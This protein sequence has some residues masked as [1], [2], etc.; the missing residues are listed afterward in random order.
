MTIPNKIGYDPKQ[1]AYERRI[2]M[3]MNAG[4]TYVPYP[5][6]HMGHP[7]ANPMDPNNTTNNNNGATPTHHG[8]QLTTSP[9]GSVVGTPTFSSPTS[10]NIN[11]Y[12]TMYGTNPTMQTPTSVQ[13]SSSN[14]YNVAP[15]PNNTPNVTP[16]AST[17]N[18]PNSGKKKRKTEGTSKKSTGGGK[19]KNSKTPKAS[20]SSTTNANNNND[21]QALPL[22]SSPTT[23]DMFS[24]NNTTVNGAT[25][26]PSPIATTIMKSSKVVK[27]EITQINEIFDKAFQN[28]TQR[29]QNISLVD[30]NHI[31]TN[32]IQKNVP[33]PDSLTLREEWKNVLQEG[34]SSILPPPADIHLVNSLQSGNN[35]TSTGVDNENSVE[36]T[37]PPMMKPLFNISHIM[38]LLFN[39]PIMEKQEKSL[40]YKENYLDISN[41]ENVNEISNFVT[42]D[43][44][45]VENI[46]ENI[47][48]D[49]E[50][51]FNKQSLQDKES[52]S[53]L[54]MIALLKKKLNEYIEKNREEMEKKLIQMGNTFN[55]YKYIQ[56]H[57]LFEL[58]KNQL[59]KLLDVSNKQ[60]EE[61]I[62]IEF[63]EQQLNMNNDNLSQNANDMDYNL[64]DTED[65]INNNN[66]S[67]DYSKNISLIEMTPKEIVMVFLGKE[68]MTQQQNQEDVNS[69]LERF[70]ELQKQYKI[71]CQY[72]D[73]GLRKWQDNF[74]QLFNEQSQIRIISFEEK[75]R[76]LKSLE[77]RFQY[78]KNLLKEKYLTKV[79]SLQ[80]NTLQRS[81]RRGNLPRHATTILK[82]WLFSHFLH[83]YPTEE[84]K[85]E[86][87]LETG[88]TL[89]QVNNWFINQRVRTWRPMLESMIES[90]KEKGDVNPATSAML[91][92]AASSGAGER[93]GSGSQKKRK[94]KS[95][96][97]QQQAPQ[98]QV[99]QQQIPPNALPVNSPPMQQNMF[100][101]EGVVYPQQQ[102]MWNNNPNVINTSN[103][104]PY[105]EQQN[106]F[107]MGGESP[108]Q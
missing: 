6:T 16:S 83:P 105:F 70:K 22:A 18:T 8:H 98:Q 52:L 87:C 38:K 33:Q 50:Q 93:G 53:N 26:N 27:E 29:F 46:I 79:L 103:P 88:L 68:G 20:T 35:G 90:E 57:K 95:T 86:L 40:I 2:A 73:D 7:N 96:N 74:T 102:M 60:Y 28:L 48:N 17:T 49:C 76:C 108:T 12:A 42:I 21:N 104:Q 72:I 30:K 47:V 45:S 71:E 107:F 101:N 55:C 51:Y 69:F 82:Q 92:A 94:R 24:T 5:A 4:G 31:E 78:I 39:Y 62:R 32:I 85:K 15:T 44:I 34:S 14:N 9:Y 13:V 19:K 67:G 89:T 43:C 106:L 80:E 65:I 97:Q 66:S 23:T 59:S 37:T 56:Q 100:T 58:L 54:E 63:V 64:M 1:I 77:Y 99:M 3:Y 11:P 41:N 84:E 91:S 36:Q 25:N 75:H 10:G 61:K 81:K